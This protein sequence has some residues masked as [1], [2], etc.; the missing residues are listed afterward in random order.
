MNSALMLMLHADPFADGAGGTEMQ[1]LDRIAALALPRAVVVYPFMADCINAALITGGNV[2][3][4]QFHSFPLK[5]PLLRFAHSHPEAEELLL[6]IARVFGVSAVSVEHALYF[7]LNALT[8]LQDAGLKL[9]TVHHDFYAVCP[10]LNLID[11][12]TYSACAAHAGQPEKSP[13][14]LSSYFASAGATPPCPA[15][16]LLAAHQRAWTAVFHRAERLVFPSESARTTTLAAYP[17]AAPRSTVIPHG[18]A[19]PPPL[20]RPRSPSTLLR[21]ALIGQVA[22][23]IKGRELILELLAAT[24]ALP[25]EWHFF[26]D[27]EY[28]NFMSRVDEVGVRRVYHGPYR[29]SAILEKLRGS[30]VDVALFTSV[31]PE[32][33]SFTLS[34]ALIAGVPPLVPRLGALAERV[35]AVRAGW[36]IAPNS[37]S[38]AAAKLNELCADRAK[39]AAEQQKLAAFQHTT[40]AQNAAAY[41]ALYAPLLQAEPTSPD[42]SELPA[43]AALYVER[44]RLRE[45]QLRAAQPAYKRSLFY[46]AYKS[47][48]HLVPVAV[49]DHLYRLLVNRGG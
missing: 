5:T 20:A 7:P 4:A 48:K 23:R 11:V 47:L 29:R 16:T 15:E 36:I 40:L 12:A 17:Q 24:R 31:C 38:A 33:F 6:R 35:E 45:Q 9:I 37:A 22:H 2:A 30:G 14:C 8:R 34:E 49:R 41:A 28:L 39:V 10:S 19:A 26:G 44:R 13:S 46:G 18:Y 25:L 3:A 21:V 42:T 27:V 1:V 32:T 43:A